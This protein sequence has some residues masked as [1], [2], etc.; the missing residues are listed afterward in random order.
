MYGFRDND[1]VSVI[2]SDLLHSY[3]PLFVLLNDG[4]TSL[5]RLGIIA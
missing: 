4:L 5:E 3:Y 2:A 1:R